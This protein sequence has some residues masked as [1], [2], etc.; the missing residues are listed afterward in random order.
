MTP[1]QKLADG[2][3]GT[4][5]PLFDLAERIVEIELDYDEIVLGHRLRRPSKQELVEHEDQVKLETREVGKNEEGEK[6]TSTTYE[7]S[8]AHCNLWDKIV[9]EVRN[10]DLEDGSEPTAWR[11]IDHNLRS[12]IPSTHK[13]TAIRGMY[14]GV[15]EVE[16][17]K[18]RK[19]FRL[20]GSQKIRVRQEIGAGEEPDFIVIH[21]LRRPSETEWSRYQSRAVSTVEVRGSKKSRIRVQTNLSAAT[22]LYDAL[23]LRIEGASIAGAGWTDSRRQEFIDLVDPKIKDQVITAFAS[24]WQVDLRD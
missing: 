15:A 17:E 24:D 16:K 20:I 18:D 13:A 9:I 6:L 19:T 5:R 4:A 23:L 14:T 1:E 22:E 3:V 7:D 10:Y 8:R 11:Q 21:I 12:L 2:E